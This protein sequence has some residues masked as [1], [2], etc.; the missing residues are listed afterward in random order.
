MDIKLNNLPYNISFLWNQM[1]EQ[2]KK[3]GD[4]EWKKRRGNPEIH[5]RK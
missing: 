4:K 3:Y 5:T 1:E 2:V